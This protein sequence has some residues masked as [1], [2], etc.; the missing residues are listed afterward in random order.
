MRNSRCARVARWGR[1]TSA[2]RFDRCAKSRIRSYP[3]RN[4]NFLCPCSDRDR[5]RTSRK[6]NDLAV[7]QHGDVT[8]RR[9]H[10][11]LLRN[12]IGTAGHLDLNDFRMK[13][14]RAGFE[15]F[16]TQ[17]AQAIC[18]RHTRQRV[19]V[20][21]LRIGS[22]RCDALRMSGAAARRKRYDQADGYGSQ[23]DAPRS[24]EDGPFYRGV[25]PCARRVHGFPYRETLT[26]SLPQTS[27]Q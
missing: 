3:R 27:V 13:D 24:Y 17:C 10:D 21:V 8:W 9:R 6:M 5:R 4:K 12:D 26:E 22:R 2:E 7:Q 23:H 20:C 14:A 19:C 25:L 18:R 1:A 15:I 11:R 16:R